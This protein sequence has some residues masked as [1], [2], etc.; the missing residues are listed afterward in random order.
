MDRGAWQATIQE[1]APSSVAPDPAESRG[2][3]PPPQD[4]SPL[5]GTLGPKSLQMV[6]A[7]MKM[8]DACSLEQAVEIEGLPSAHFSSSAP[9]EK[10][11]RSCFQ[12]TRDAQ[13]PPRPVN[14]EP[15]AGARQSL[16]F[17][18]P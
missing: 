12:L 15:E 1:V 8:K 17:F 2:A 14:P 4:S 3:L 6:T 16:F 13:A 7:A 9:S 11:Q 18:S 10:P 5:R